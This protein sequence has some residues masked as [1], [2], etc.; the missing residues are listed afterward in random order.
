MCACKYTLLQAY[1]IMQLHW[2]RQTIYSDMCRSIYIHSRYL[3]VYMHMA[4]EYYVYIF[5]IFTCITSNFL[6]II[7]QNIILEYIITTFHYV[8]GYYI[9][10][11]CII[12][13]FITL[14]YITLY[15][16]ILYY[17]ILY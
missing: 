7:L 14:H 8:V 10:L 15:Y 5:I 11:Y 3:S 4:N 9:T 2:C 13:Y 17:I 12:L 6:I 1:V 16:I